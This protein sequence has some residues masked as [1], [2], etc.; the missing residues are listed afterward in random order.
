MDSGGH[1]S[2]EEKAWQGMEAL[3][4]QELPKKSLS[5]RPFLPYAA[6][7]FIGAVAGL[8]VWNSNIDAPYQA[9][10]KVPKVLSLDNMLLPSDFKVDANELPPLYIPGIDLTES[11][12]QAVYIEALPLAQSSTYAPSTIGSQERP[13]KLFGSV[14]PVV[15]SNILPEGKSANSISELHRQ[16]NG[17]PDEL[18]LLAQADNRRVNIDF[19]PTLPK[20]EIDV[21][22]GHQPKKPM[23]QGIVIPI[24]S[25]RNAL[26]QSS[27]G[28][29]MEGAA[30]VSTNGFD[31]YGLD[32]GIDFTK[33][34]AGN[35]SVGTGINVSNYDDTYKGTYQSV[36]PQRLEN[37]SKTIQQLNTRSVNRSFVEVPVYLD[38]QV[39][40]L[41]NFRAGITVTYNNNDPSA[42]R[43]TQSEL[44]ESDL[45]NSTKHF[46]SQLYHGTGGYMGEAVVGANV[47]LKRIAV[48]GELI[49]G[50]LSN[51]TLDQRSIARLKLSYTF[52]K[53]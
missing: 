22:G 11:L 34:V 40:D 46:A 51:S 10:N 32:V 24:S 1:N 3:L 4:D 29:E 5:I 8:L 43:M 21:L 33:K 39:N 23:Q 41:T 48:E 6:T 16:I 9:V 49:Q 20:Y 12:E 17:I 7:L 14:S 36:V 18:N 31:S 30:G 47:Q 26:V 37:A 19:E 13:T 42:P 35:L 50:V 44:L 15:Q 53:K 25:S 28:I 38:Y 45:D 2:L 27:K 52:G